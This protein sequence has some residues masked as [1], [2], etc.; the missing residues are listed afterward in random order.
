M[1]FAVRGFFENGG[2]RAYVARVAADGAA[3]TPEAF[4]GDATVPKEART[5]FAGLAIIDDLQLLVAPDEVNARI[6]NNTRIAQA[7]VEQCETR[8]D[9]F[10]ILSIRPGQ[11]EV[12]EIVPPRDSSYAAVYYPWLRVPAGQGQAP[13]LVPPAGHVAG[14]CARTDRERGVH[15]APANEEVRGLA[16]GGGTDPTRAPLEFLIG[17]SEQDLLNSRGVNVIRDFRSAGRGVR[18]WGART[19]SSDPEWKYVNLRRLLLFVESSI[20]RGTDWA[21]FEPSAESLWTQVRQVV[22]DFLLTIWRS[23]A[24]QGQTPKEAF[25]VRCGRD[26]MTQADIDLG[27]L[28]CLVGVAPVRPSEFTIVRIRQKTAG[29]RARPP[30]I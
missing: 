26:T 8:R 18:V 20:Q 25:F 22:E 19:M 29:S 15:K 24:L 9:R 6:P 21:T 1:P 27:R 13:I 10:G 11:Q 3:L 17:A 4:L 12:S 16:T 30:G 5:G 7:V 28:T 14:I 23:G 2:E